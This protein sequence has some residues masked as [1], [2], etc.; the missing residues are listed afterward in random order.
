MA[1]PNTAKAVRGGTIIQA[2]YTI[3]YACGL[4]DTTHMALVY[5]DHSDCALVPYVN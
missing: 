4:P 1:I 3:G 5:V 2:S